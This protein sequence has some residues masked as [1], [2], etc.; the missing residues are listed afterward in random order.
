MRGRTKWLIA[1]I[2]AV[3]V[4]S[5]FITMC[6][7]IERERESARLPVAIE[8]RDEPAHEIAVQAADGSTRRIAAGS[9]RFLLLH[10]WAT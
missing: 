8:R 3:A 10:F 1:A 9:G 2:A 5:A 6:G 4:Q 7:R